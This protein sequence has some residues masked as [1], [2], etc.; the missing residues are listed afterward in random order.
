M[1]GGTGNDW[2]V[3]YTD[4]FGKGCVG[5]VIVKPVDVD[6]TDGVLTGTE[7]KELWDLQGKSRD[8]AACI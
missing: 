8:A 6:E 1:I 4:T 5:T 7:V 2:V 3:P